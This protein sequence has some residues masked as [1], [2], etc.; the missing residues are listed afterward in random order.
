MV[1][2]DVF[3]SPYQTTTIQVA[4]KVHI[5]AF[6]LS[7]DIKNFYIIILKRKPRNRGNKT[8]YHLFCNCRELTQQFFKNELR[9]F[10]YV[11]YFYRH[12]QSC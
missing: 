12:K 3:A 4:D 1:I 5:P 7:Y 2:D 8:V 11:P 6:L 9:F 10:Q